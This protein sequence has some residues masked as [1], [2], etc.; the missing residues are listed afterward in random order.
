MDVHARG[1]DPLDRVEV[2]LEG[3]RDRPPLALVPH[4]H[5]ERRLDAGSGECGA[6]VVQVRAQVLLD[7]TGPVAADLDHVETVLLREANLVY[8]RSAV[9]AETTARPP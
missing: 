8:R 5:L 7:R 3:A 6:D 1:A 9:V 4:E 2:R